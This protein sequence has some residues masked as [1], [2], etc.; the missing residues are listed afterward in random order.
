MSFRGNTGVIAGFQRLAHQ[1]YASV[2]ERASFYRYRLLQMALIFIFT[3]RNA[4]KIPE[5][6]ASYWAVS[7]RYIIPSIMQI[8]II[9]IQISF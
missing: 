4:N 3:L 9:Q 7:E 6:A 2:G 5:E 1:L 8:R